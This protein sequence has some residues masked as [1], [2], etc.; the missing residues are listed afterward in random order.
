M[1][2]TSLRASISHPNEHKLRF[3]TVGKTPYS[4]ERSHTL[5]GCVPFARE[6]S[7]EIERPQS[8][9]RSNLVINVATSFVRH[10]EHNHT[11]TSDKNSST[12][13]SGFTQHFS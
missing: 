5:A 9:G 2:I 8:H 4:L 12:D 10:H 3:T 11:R 7:F 6:A 1:E 13:I